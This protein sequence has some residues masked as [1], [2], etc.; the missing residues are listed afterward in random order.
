LVPIDALREGEL[1][2]QE[3]GQRNGAKNERAGRHG[4]L[5]RSGAHDR[6]VRDA[7]HAQPRLAIR[8]MA[9]AGTPSVSD[10]VELSG[11]RPSSIWRSRL[12][13]VSS[14]LRLAAIA[15]ASTPIIAASAPRISNAPPRISD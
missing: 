13:A 12:R 3:H 6:G 4:G 15:S 5:G 14:S 10:S 8:A 11:G 9:S 2:L 7:R 1:D